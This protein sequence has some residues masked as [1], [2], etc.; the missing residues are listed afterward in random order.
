MMMKLEA[1][2]PLLAGALLE[3]LRNWGATQ[4]FK[5]ATDHHLFVRT[6]QVNP[7]DNSFPLL[8]AEAVLE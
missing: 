2:V 6:L 3:K 1:A 4:D 8:L 5:L 7:K